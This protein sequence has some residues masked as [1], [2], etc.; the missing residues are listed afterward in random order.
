MAQDT[1]IKTS[2]KRAYAK[3]YLAGIDHSRQLSNI[4][5]LTVSGSAKRGYSKGLKHG[6]Y[7]KKQ[8]MIVKAQRRGE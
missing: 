6:T 7:Q 8:K 1:Y 2:K 4:H 3:G 5:K